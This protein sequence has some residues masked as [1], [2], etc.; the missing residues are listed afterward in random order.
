MPE[1][2]HVNETVIDLSNCHLN[3]WSHYGTGEPIVSVRLKHRMHV[4]D[5]HKDINIAL[6]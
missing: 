3:F 1:I 6:P 2:Q 4:Q 5:A